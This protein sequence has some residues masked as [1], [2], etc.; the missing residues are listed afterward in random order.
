M[1]A[2]DPDLGASLPWAV[3]GVIRNAGIEAAI[4]GLASDADS[5][6][7]VGYV[8]GSGGNLEGTFRASWADGTMNWVEDCHGDTY[9]VAPAGDVIY[10]TGHAHYCGNV[11]G[12]PQSD[13]VDLQP[14][15]GVLASTRTARS[16]SDPYG[17]YNF[18][19]QPKPDILHWYPTINA[20]TFT[21]IG[22][23]PWDIAAN[24]QYVILG[25]EFTTVNN[26]AKQGLVRYAD[27]HHRAEH[28]RPAH[29]AATRSTRGSS[30]RSPAVMRVT[31]PA[32]WDRDDKTLR[33]R[34]Y[35]DGRT[36]TAIYETLV[37]S[38]TWNLPTITFL[39]TGLEPGSVHTYRV[40][41]IDQSPNATPNSAWSS[42]VEGTVATTGTFSSYA[43]AVVADQPT[44]YWRL[45]DAVGSSVTHDTVG[46]D[47]GTS[48]SGVTF[49]QAGA[50]IGDPD[51]AARFTGNQSGDNSLASQNTRIW[52]E[53]TVT[54][55]A[56]FRTS[57]TS[58]GKIVGFGSS[59]TG[60]SS[61][62][63][64]HIFMTS[65]GRV[66]WGVYSGAERRLQSIKSYNDNQWH[67]VVATLGP[68]GTSLY[69]D[70]I[71]VARDPST[72]WGQNYWGYW[73]I[74][75][76]N[77]WEGARYLNGFIDEVAIYPT[78]LTPSQVAN[79]FT[80]SGR[81]IAAPT[82]PTDVYGAAV[83]A[84]EPLL[85][86]RLNEQSG[87]SAA[88]SGQLGINGT[89]TGSY[90]RGVAGVLDGVD[91]DSSQFTSGWARSAISFANPTTY[92]EEAWFNTTTTQGGKIM[93][94]GTG[95]TALSSSYD[96]H[97][98][99]QDDGSLVF[100]TWTG[101]TNTIT[102]IPGY[103]D[104]LWHHVVAAQGSGGMVL[105]VDGELVGTNPQTGAESYT[106]YWRI[107]GDNTWSS[108]SPYFNGRIDE[109]AVYPV[110]LSPETVAEHYELGAPAAAQPG[111][112]RR[113]HHHR[114]RQEGHLR[115]H[116]VERLRRH[117]RRV[118][119]GLRRRRDEHRGEPGAQLHDIEHLQRDVDGH[120]RR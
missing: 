87:N 47:D 38:D 120:G 17:Y 88:D 32:N 78:A 66:Q 117:D 24:S 15:P 3:N 21:G 5:V 30:P 67:Q 95:T 94:F 41:V 34:V 104:G 71:R 1:V 33:Y 62:Y 28:R 91:N 114:G 100:G 36:A 59:R 42:W 56:W 96:R 6:Y 35:R 98:Y 9:S 63:D 2:V 82:P 50:I 83:H 51:T 70:G 93:G 22:Q 49:G 54:V 31:L 101:A 112:G 102:S 40:Q 12:K 16:R 64:R 4:Y 85:Y 65:N 57:S 55:E 60:R 13:T 72:T 106:G 118:P 23:G 8:F 80:L 69:I 79:H 29:R 37:D 14:R 86:W 25:G 115:L 99:M 84:D 108:S 52:R 61:N 89:F 26:Q 73:R 48:R 11:E 10:T 111:S 44:Y 103:N 81:T 97:V 90:T 116:A 74:G 68:D 53:N 105:Y 58:G 39:D 45:G 110:V 43:K 119:L 107:G 46:M 75:G 7:G 27:P 77:T 113:L 109:F 76:D 19:G 18:Q 92:T 20:G